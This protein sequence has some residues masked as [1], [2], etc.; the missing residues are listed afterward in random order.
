MQLY[1]ALK[2]HIWLDPTTFGPTLGAPNY[3]TVGV[4]G[5]KFLQE[6]LLIKICR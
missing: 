1:T 3:E 2:G 6:I 4:R 5:L